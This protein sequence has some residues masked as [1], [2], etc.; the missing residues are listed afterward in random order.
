MFTAPFS[1]YRQRGRRR[2]ACVGDSITA[3]QIGVY[4]DI[5]WP[6]RLS[7]MS[8]WHVVNFGVGG[9]TSE[10]IRQTFIDSV[11][12]R[13]FTD[14][15]VMG[16]VNDIIRSEDPVDTANNVMQIADLA[17]DETVWIMQVLP[18]GDYSFSAFN[19]ADTATCNAALTGALPTYDYFGSDLDPWNMV[20]EWTDDGLHPNQTGADVMA[21]YVYNV[22]LNNTGS[23]T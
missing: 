1:N 15:V 9:Y 7:K 13:Y 21:N 19:E 10:Q 22:L 18:F 20:P 2:I 23:I 14:V 4:L 8:G 3:G 17:Q 6:L 11:V 5:P 12:G 16:G